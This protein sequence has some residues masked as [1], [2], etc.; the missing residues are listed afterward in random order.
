MVILSL[1]ETQWERYYSRM[2][3]ATP[4]TKFRVI[5]TGVEH[6][7]WTLYHWATGDSLGIM[8]Y[9][10]TLMKSDPTTDDLRN[11]NN[12]YH[13][14]KIVIMN[15]LLEFTQFSSFTILDVEILS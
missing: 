5:P 10:Y 15:C 11:K 14:G 2:T 6:I 3:Q 8:P 4:K 12:I 13:H 7:G 1:V 9:T